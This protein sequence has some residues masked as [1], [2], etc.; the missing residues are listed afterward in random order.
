MDDPAVKPELKPLTP[1]ERSRTYEF[2]GGHRVTLANVTRFLARES[3][4][5]RL[6][7]AD[8]RLHIIPAGWLHIEIDAEGWSL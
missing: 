4:T 8:G 3:G 2:P 6:E 1:P 7:T 5:H